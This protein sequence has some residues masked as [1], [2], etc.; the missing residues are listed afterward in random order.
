MRP[1]WWR[2]IRFPNE[3][4]FVRFLIEYYY[5]FSP[6]LRGNLKFKWHFWGILCFLIRVWEWNYS[7]IV[8]ETFDL[9][10]LTFIENRRRKKRKRK[11]TRLLRVFLEMFLFFKISKFS[12]FLWSEIECEKTEN[13]KMSHAWDPTGK[14][15][16]I[17]VHHDTESPQNW[18][19]YRKSTRM[20]RIEGL[21]KLR[22]TRR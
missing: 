16:S 11:E 20:E 6:F 3:A 19:Y 12:L 21:E 5:S 15:L 9:D 17:R 2:H 1:V 10:R 8:L 7:R 4:I 22:E 14:G 18:Y 13:E